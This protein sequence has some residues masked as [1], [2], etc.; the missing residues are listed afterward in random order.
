MSEQ[1][2]RTGAY[3]AFIHIYFF[4]YY[5]FEVELLITETITTITVLLVAGVGVEKERLQQSPSTHSGAGGKE[6]LNIN[7]VGNILV[8]FGERK[9]E[10]QTPCRR[11][12]IVKQL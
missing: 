3:D 11:Q 6:S 2:R 1:A 10:C 4:I 7:V 12:A 9:L 8:V 5:L